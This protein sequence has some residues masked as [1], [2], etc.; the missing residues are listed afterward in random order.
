MTTTN[1]DSAMS[2]R[3]FRLGPSQRILLLTVAVAAVAV[4]LFVVVVRHLPTAPTAL[5]LPWVLWAVAF[6]ASEVMVVHVQWQRDAH[7]FSISDL[8]L[9]AGFPQQHVERLS[10][11][12]G[13]Q[14]WRSL[15]VIEQFSNTSPAVAAG[16]LFIRTDSHLYR[17]ANNGK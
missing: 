4:A 12:T 14:V 15:P 13:E 7:T 8:V 3:M 2:T 16:S 11:I 1:S 17:I 10:S 9:A 5:N 6:A